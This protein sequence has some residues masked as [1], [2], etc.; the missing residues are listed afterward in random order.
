MFQLAYSYFEN[1]NE[2]DAIPENRVSL[3]IHS[4]SVHLPHPI[5]Y[6]GSKRLLAPQILSILH[7]KTCRRFYEPFTGS[8]AMTIAASHA[9][10]AEEYVLGDILSPLMNIWDSILSSPYALANAY[11]QIWYEQLQQDVDY[12]NRIREQ[13][14]ASPQSAL[15]LYLLARCVKNAPRFNRQGQ[16]NQS[17][18]KR[19]LGMH[20]NKMRQGLLKASVLLHRH[21]QTRCGDFMKTLEDATPEDIVYLDPPYEGTSTGSDQRYYQSLEHTRLIE[22][23]AD[24]NERHIPFLLSYDGRCGN[25]TYGEVLPESLNVT[26]LEL[27][28]GR[29]SQSTLNG[30]SDVTVESLYVSNSLL[31]G[32]LNARKSFLACSSPALPLPAYAGA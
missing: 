12:Y 26:R 23:L 30:G 7:G 29:S 9:H 14:N 2:Q 18:D 22:S 1:D 25:K 13:Y 20:P 19:R 24:L 28:A 15:L 16:F 8:G 32:F 17:H 3:V 11:E 4:A 5:P 6:Q 27:H 10:I 31:T 21:T